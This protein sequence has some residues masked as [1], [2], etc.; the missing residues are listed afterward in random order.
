VNPRIGRR[1]WDRGTYSRDRLFLGRRPLIPRASTAEPAA[2]ARVRVEI[3]R[4][5]IPA[6]GG[7]VN[8]WALGVGVPPW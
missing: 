6:V 3:G 7:R 1:F 8:W 2:V 5:K 4:A